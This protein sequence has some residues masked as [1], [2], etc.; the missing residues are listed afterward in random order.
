MT[1]RLNGKARETPEGV[2]IAGLLESLHLNPLRVAVLLNEEVIKRERHGQVI[3]KEG[4][5][6]EVLTMM[7]GG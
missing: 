5:R 6:V 7:A 4:D 3:L 2:S 1:I